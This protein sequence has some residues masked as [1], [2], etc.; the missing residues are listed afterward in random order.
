[1]RK[2][3]KFFYGA[4]CR[5]ISILHLFKVA[6]TRKFSSRKTK[7]AYMGPN[8]IKLFTATIHEFS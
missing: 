2:G 1:V 8:P 4:I 6:A 7:G 3:E 5:K